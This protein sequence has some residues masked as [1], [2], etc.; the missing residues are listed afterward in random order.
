MSKNKKTSTTLIWLLVIALL[1]VSIIAV[2]VIGMN[3]KEK[4]PAPN[5]IPTQPE[6]ETVISYI[7]VEHEITA[8]IIEDGLK[9][10]GTLETADYYF[11]QV[12]NY[13]DSKTKS[14][15]FYY[16]EKLFSFFS[17]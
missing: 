1:A 13:S 6:K 9:E 7:E 17:S 14:V 16:L 4:Q 10:I 12:I 3:K 2:V 8:Q 5:L 11:T 15:S